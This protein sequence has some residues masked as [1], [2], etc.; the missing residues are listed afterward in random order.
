M[1]N[2]FRFF[3]KNVTWSQMIKRDRLRREIKKLKGSILDLGCGSGEYSLIMSKKKNNLVTALDIVM[4]PEF[5]KINSKNIKKI[6]SDAHNLPFEDNSFDACLI[7]DVLEHVKDSGTI[8]SEVRRVLKPDG[9]LVINMPFL[10]ELHA[11]PEDY[12][13]YTSFGLKNLLNKYGFN[14]VKVWSDNG[15]LFSIEYLLL[16]S[17]VWRLRLGFKR[18][19]FVGY[20]YILFL[21][22]LFIFVKFFSLI[23][24]LFQKDD[25]HFFTTVI[26]VAK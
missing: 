4:S 14:D 7:A 18:N 9:I 1:M 8:L 11:D 25:D 17:F 21:I 10:L 24:Y 5:E 23:F 3:S 6:I 22:F 2:L 12:R 16:G 20:V 19:F 13:R 26:A 15:A